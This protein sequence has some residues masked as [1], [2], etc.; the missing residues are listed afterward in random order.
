MKAAIDFYIHVS[1]LP[2]LSYLSLFSVSPFSVLFLNAM[3][4]WQNIFFS[5]FVH[6]QYELRK[7][8]L[9]KF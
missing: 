7:V 4:S 8:V 2:A 6:Q 5:S 1:S 3:M 9:T